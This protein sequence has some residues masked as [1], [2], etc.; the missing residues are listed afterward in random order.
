MSHAARGGCGDPQ[1]ICALAVAVV[2]SSLGTSLVPLARIT[3]L[4]APS[5]LAAIGTAICLPAVA[6]RANKEQRA[7]L[8]CATE[9]LVEKLT[10]CTRS[11][12]PDDNRTTGPGQ[13]APSAMMLIL[14][15]ICPNSYAFT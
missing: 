7:A 11:H 6:A 9:A 13:G 2:E 1:A 10:V 8:R 3:P 14:S 15:A 12:H 4:L 5:N